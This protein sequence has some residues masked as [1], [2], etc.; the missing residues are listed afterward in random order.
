[1]YVE[2][3][4]R[5]TC[6]DSQFLYLLRISLVAV[7]LWPYHR[8][9]LVQFQSCVFSLTTISFIIFQLTTLLTK[10][11][12]EWTID[13]I[14]E[15][16]S[17]SLFLFLCVIPYNFIWINS[18][19]VTHILENLQYVCSELKDENEGA[20]IKRYGH[21]AK[22][23]A[24]GLTLLAICILIIF[25]VLPILP[26]IFD[27]FFLVNTSESYRNIYITTEYFVDKEKYFYFILLHMYAAHYIALG[28]L[29]GAGILWTGY[30]IYFCGLFAIASYRI[31]QAMRINNSDEITNRKDKRKIDK[32]IS[33]AV[34]IHRAAVELTEFF[35][36]NL[37]ETCILLMAIIL[38][39]LSLNL[40]G[41]VHAI[42]F[43]FSMENFLLHCGFTLTTLTAS[44]GG[45]YAGQEITDHYNYIF[46]SAYN[47]RWYVAPVRVQRLIL[48]LLQKGTKPYRMKFGGLYI[49]S[50]E[51]FASVLTASISYFTVI[52]SIQK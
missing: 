31:E 6:I 4:T 20:I 52:Y 40:F 42:N 43:V 37:E 44:L 12:T 8:T 33:H 5:V 26:R 27:I 21:I 14:V 11:S 23:V 10:N 32:K 13:F 24:I 34:D 22:C 46:S 29:I 36:Y 47:I 41:I 17:K 49:T 50:L 28:T 25:T 38:I 18:H 35:I 9:M 15:I 7:G 39:C 45:H 3:R 19:C 2:A 30:C 51:N 48:F 16:L 1:M